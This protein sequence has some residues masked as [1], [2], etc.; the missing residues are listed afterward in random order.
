MATELGRYN[1]NVN[2]VC[3]GVI[4]PEKP[5]HHGKLSRW[6]QDDRAEFVSPQV[7]EGLTKQTPLLRLG[8]PEDIATATVFLA[9]APANFITGQT[10]SVDSGATM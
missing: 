8:K 9:S 1:I 10:L 3:S 6:S 5:E 2:C 4:L 7:V